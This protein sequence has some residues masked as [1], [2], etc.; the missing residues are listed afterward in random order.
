MFKVGLT[1]SQLFLV[2]YL[3]KFLLE[4]FLTLI[5]SDAR[6]VIVLEKDFTD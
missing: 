6:T 4:K 5:A 2:G 3:I 1:I